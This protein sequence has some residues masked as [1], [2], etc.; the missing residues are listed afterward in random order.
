[1]GWKVKLGESKYRLASVDS[2]EADYKGLLHTAIIKIRSR[3]RCGK[4]LPYKLKKLMKISAG[5]QNGGVMYI[6][7]A[8]VPMYVK[9]T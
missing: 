3:D 5:I 1:M 4:S 6:P 2:I 9:W 8:P 7:R